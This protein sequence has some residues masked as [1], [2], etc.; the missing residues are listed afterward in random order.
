MHY[1]DAPA[2][3]GAQELLT[4]WHRVEKKKTLVIRINSLF[5]LVYQCQR[6]RKE[7][8]RE[9]ERKGGRRR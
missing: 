2:L 8:E 3:P 1:T 7:E 5:I 9:R 4:A 6:R